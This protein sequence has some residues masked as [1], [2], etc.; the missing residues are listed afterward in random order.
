MLVQSSGALRAVDLQC[1]DTWL[2][3]NAALNE[4]KYVAQD[5][6]RRARD[7]RQFVPAEF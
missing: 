5:I 6:S 7:R 1:C 4:K 2:E 3:D